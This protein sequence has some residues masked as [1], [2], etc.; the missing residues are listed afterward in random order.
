MI[1]VEAKQIGFYG[2]RRR[3]PKGHA[4]Y[5]TFLVDKVDGS[6]MRVVEVKEKPTLAELNQDGEQ[7]PSAPQDGQTFVNDNEPATVNESNGEVPLSRMKKD[8]LIAISVER[9][10]SENVDLTQ[11]NRSQLIGLIQESYEAEQSTSAPETED[12]Q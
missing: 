12:N 8:D 5:E 10:L 2:N 9:G 11:L 3:Y 4:K 7:S 1:E 6:W